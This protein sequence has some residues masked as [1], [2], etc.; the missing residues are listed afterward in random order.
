MARIG[1]LVPS[2]NTSVETE[3]YRL[4]PP[5]VTVHTARLLLTHITPETLLGML[6]DLDTQ[7]R[8]LAS[9]GV[10]VIVLG[11]VAPALTK[12]AGY[13]RELAQRIETAAGTRATTTATALLD[14]L[15]HMKLRRV[16]IAAPYDASISAMATSFLQG[17]GI[18][19]VATRELGLV[20]N[21][22]VGRLTEADAYDLGRAADRADA[23]A[24]IFAGTNMRT[25]AVVERLERELG[26]PVVSTTAAALWAAL[27]LVG[28]SG[29]IA[30]HG[31]LLRE[32]TQ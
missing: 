17:N 23:D 22:Q 14:A 29:S 26:K 7:S 27:R 5:A 12:G 2:S 16:A 13:D 20:D 11:A 8:L 3:F 19:V 30:G 18:G 28:F 21:Q 9:A 31:R 10:D 6:S 25:M 24:V 4:L 15:H 1:L 32:I